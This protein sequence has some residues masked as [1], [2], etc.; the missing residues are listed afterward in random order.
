MTACFWRY[1]EVEARAAAVT[2]LLGGASPQEF[3]A[4]PAEQQAAQLASL[5]GTSIMASLYH[6]PAPADSLLCAGPSGARLA[7]SVLRLEDDCCR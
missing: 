7:C 2:P 6:L 5:A 4:W 3:L 1:A